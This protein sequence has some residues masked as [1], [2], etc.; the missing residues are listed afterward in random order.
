MICIFLVLI[1]SLLV[2][3][4]LGYVIAAMTT[5][6]IVFSFFYNHIPIVQLATIETFIEIGL[7]FYLILSMIFKRNKHIKIFKI[8]I[9]VFLAAIAIYISFRYKIVWTND[10]PLFGN[11]YATLFKFFSRILESLLRFFTGN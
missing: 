8:I 3:L 7:I 6:P 5:I 10:I 1:F 11:L 2:G 9:P 4:V